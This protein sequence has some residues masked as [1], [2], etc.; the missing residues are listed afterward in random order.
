MPTY[1]YLCNDCG[2]E[3]ERIH[4]F[5]KT[6]EPCECGSSNIKIVINQV[7]MGFVKGEPTTLGQLAESNT[8]RWDT[9]SFRT[10]G[11]SMKKAILKTKSQKSGGRSL[12]MQ[13]NLKSTKCQR[14]RKQGT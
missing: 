13:P 9:M 5:G 8:K 1:D 12:E 3:F 10:R 14:L 2:S 7:P 4:G 11:A 6:P